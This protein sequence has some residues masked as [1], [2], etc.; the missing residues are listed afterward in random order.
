MGRSIRVAGTA[1]AAA[2]IETAAAAAAGLAGAGVAAAELAAAAAAVSGM[3]AELVGAEAGA[4]VTAGVGG[5]LMSV[6]AGLM[7]VREP[8]G[9]LYLT[10]SSCTAS[11]TNKGLYRA[12]NPAV[13]LAVPDHWLGLLGCCT[14]LTVCSLGL[15]KHTTLYSACGHRVLPMCV[16]TACSTLHSWVTLAELVL[17]SSHKAF[18]C[19]RSGRLV[20]RNLLTLKL[21]S[22]RA[23]ESEVYI[24][25]IPYCHSIS[26]VSP[27]VC[28]VQT[29][30]C[31]CASTASAAA[32]GELQ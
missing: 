10:S 2:A 30:R 22:Q 23:E 16:G 5:D 25:V 20:N 12:A 11:P 14:C 3:M 21:L 19:W 8:V 13:W 24:A 29:N 28:D 27:V 17:E 18:C 1:A 32:A 4:E 9:W 7:L 15:Y 26:V 6:V 31:E